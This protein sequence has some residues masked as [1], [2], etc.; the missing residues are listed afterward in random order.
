MT[1]KRR[2]RRLETLGLIFESADKFQGLISVS[3]NPNR[4]VAI[5]IANAPMYSIYKDL[6]CSFQNQ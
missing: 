6:K 1:Q 4:L 2:H 3:S 5:I